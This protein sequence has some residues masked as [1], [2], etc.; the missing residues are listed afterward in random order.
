[1][2]QRTQSLVERRVPEQ[3]EAGEHACTNRLQRLPYHLVKSFAH[4]IVL[5][6]YALL[7]TTREIDS[8]TKTSKGGSACVTE[9]ERSMVTRPLSR[10][11]RCHARISPRRKKHALSS[12]MC[13]EQ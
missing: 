13:M 11:L 8:S 12:P 2:M 5:G 3:R 4:A 1:M 6:S 7:D 10:L 9:H